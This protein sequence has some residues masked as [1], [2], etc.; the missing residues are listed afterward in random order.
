MPE[1][2]LRFSTRLPVTTDLRFG[3]AP[4]SPGSY[5]TATIAASVTVG[6]TAALHARTGY[7]GTVDAAVDVGFAAN[8]TA[9]YDNAVNR[10]PF[11]WQRAVWATAE[12][13]ATDTASRHEVAPKCEVSVALPLLP[14]E[15]RR[16]EIAARWEWMAMGL[17]PEARLSWREAAPL[18]SEA[19][20]PH[21][22]LSRANRPAIVAPWGAAAAHDADASDRWIDL[23][24]HRRP[25]PR[26]LWAEAR[27]AGMTLTPAFGAGRAIRLDVRIPWQEAR[28]P[29]PGIS[30]V[31]VV[32]PGHVPCYHPV[33][34]APVALRFWELASTVDLDLRFRCPHPDGGGVTETVVIPVRRV[35]M[36]TNTVTLVIADTGQPLFAR[37]L[38]LSLDADS[39]CWGWSAI[40]GGQYLSL[41]APTGGGQV[42]LIATLNGTAFRLA[43]E[44]IRRERSFGHSAL[45]LSGR[46]RAAWLAEPYA[47][48]VSRTNAEA[49]TAQQ[50]MADALTENGVSL[51][52][53]LDWQ[54]T[55]WLVPAGAWSHTGT[56]MG[57]CL[58]IAGAAGA[59]IQAHRTGQTLA[60]L[61][62]YPSAPWTW[63]G[64]TPDI[65]LPED[66]CV[67]EGIEWLDKPAYNTVFL[68]G[69]TGGIIAHVTRSGTAGD[70]PAPMVT[71]PLI[72]H[73]DAARQRGTAIL[74][75]TGR[76]KLISLSLPVLAETGIIVPG[77]FVRYTEG[78]TQHIGLTRAVEVGPDFPKLRQTITVE[79]HV[80]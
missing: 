71:D 44:R 69:Q 10:G 76:Q 52:W 8:L 9:L 27:R 54:I 48:I 29:L 49:M 7:L 79:S 47:D 31:I 45:S 57:A 66:V 13:L 39:W 56:A 73:A 58:A 77:K 4:W 6:A 23:L 14:G 30:A 25:E 59:Y 68:S 55:D 33:H 17:R 62:R 36:Q 28:H 12:P 80:L 20:A 61:P 75:D 51:G 5:N 21:A 41:L 19:A 15:R 16:A 11:A 74:A 18:A 32:P 63:G 65:Q 1:T 34:G 78:G 35:Y 26:L 2:D 24:R 43:V 38:R 22:E 50:L 42:E 67:T 60:V 53:D 40:V 37:N 70:K 64:V 72:T 3:L 46:G